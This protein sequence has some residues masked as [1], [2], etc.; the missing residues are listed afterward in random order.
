MIDHAVYGE[1]WGIFAAAGRGL[2]S[3]RS[4]CR[5]ASRLLN[6][7]RR[8][9]KSEFLSAWNA[10]TGSSSNFLLRYQALGWLC[11]MIRC[12]FIRS[13]SIDETHGDPGTRLGIHVGGLKADAN[14]KAGQ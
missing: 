10:R 5:S 8:A 14:D 9:P 11:S 3:F 13:E 7:T 12:M 1:E 4:T 2:W 6:K